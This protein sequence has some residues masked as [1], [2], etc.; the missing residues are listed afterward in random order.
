M[1]TKL[2]ALIVGLMLTLGVGSAAGQ[3]GS[4]PELRTACQPIGVAPSD[5]ASPGSTVR[6]KIQPQPFVNSSGATMWRAGRGIM[7]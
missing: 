1:N 4:C 7:Y 6:P 3:A 5:S 2:I